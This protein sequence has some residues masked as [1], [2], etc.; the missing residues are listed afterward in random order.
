[1][2]FPQA[3]HT[4][5]PPC[6][7]SGNEAAPTAQEERTKEL[8]LTI[9]T[10]TSLWDDLGCILGCSGS[11]CTGSHQSLLRTWSKDSQKPFPNSWKARS[12]LGAA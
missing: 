4:P 10:Y 11:N 9:S 5:E 3:Y 1:M 2:D 12:V 8:F 6:R 7:T